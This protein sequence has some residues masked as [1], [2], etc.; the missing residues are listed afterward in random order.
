[1][2]SNLPDAGEPAVA[3]QQYN[4]P[5]PQGIAT[6]MHQGNLYVE[7]PSANSNRSLPPQGT[8]YVIPH[9][10]GNGVISWI[11]GP[12]SSQQ[13]SSVP[14]YVNIST[15]TYLQY[16]L[17]TYS[18]LHVCIRTHRNHFFVTSQTPSVPAS[19]VPQ[20]QQPPVSSHPS[21]NADQYN[22]PSQANQ[23]KKQLED[24]KKRLH[25]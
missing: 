20:P 25:H 13:P 18:Y 21:T 8:G 15:H 22:Q 9:Y 2:F 11:V 6:T 17:H 12:S 1:M 19:T 23:H 3:T 24:Q 4:L 7:L 16:Y 10:S 14:K 5:N